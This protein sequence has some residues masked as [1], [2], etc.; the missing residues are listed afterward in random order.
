M[1]EIGY[2]ARRM[3]L[4]LCAL[5]AVQGAAAGDDA[6]LRDPTRPSGWHAAQDT[7]ADGRRPVDALRLQGTFSVGG[8]RSALVSGQ[9]VL[10]GDRVAGAQV[11]GI[12]RNRV[13]L[14]VDGETVELAAATAPVK[15]PS[16]GEQEGR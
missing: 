11:V 5:G 1:S 12:D 15:S 4:L 13:I 9:R 8:E 16:N 2:H 7:S 10:V 3:S 14:R 6:A